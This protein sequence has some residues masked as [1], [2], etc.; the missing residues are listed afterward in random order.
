M[1][2]LHLDTCKADEC[3]ARVLLNRCQLKH[4]HLMEATQSQ[5]LLS[6]KHSRSLMCDT[7]GQEG[8]PS[9]RIC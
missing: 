6:V 5:C 7:S 3:F 4:C 8:I 2:S 1:K 9:S